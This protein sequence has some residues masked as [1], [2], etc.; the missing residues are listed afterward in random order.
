MAIA[1]GKVTAACVL[2]STRRKNKRPCML[3]VMGDAVEEVCG[4]AAS[5]AA[6]LGVEVEAT[7]KAVCKIG[8][9][10]LRPSALVAYLQFY[11]ALSQAACSRVG[12]GGGSACV[13]PGCCCFLQKVC[14]SRLNLLISANACTEWLHGC[15]SS[16][17]GLCATSMALSRHCVMQL[18]A[19]TRVAGQRGRG[20]PMRQFASSAA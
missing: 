12:S 8:L 18:V 15:A 9:L 4:A 7:D 11:S 1:A 16:K 6:E 10:V 2:F 20:Y 5:G 14:R 17:E 19:S 13:P 3:G